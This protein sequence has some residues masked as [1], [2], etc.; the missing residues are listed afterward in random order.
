[1]TRA[2]DAPRRRFAA[3]GL[4]LAPQP[5]SGALGSH[6]SRD[7]GAS[8][9]PLLGVLDGPRDVTAVASNPLVVEVV[10]GALGRF[11]ARPYDLPGVRPFVENG[12]TLLSRSRET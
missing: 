5:D 1:M 3:R 2:R 6:L 12:R 10:N 11:S 4:L 8:G 7:T 9:K